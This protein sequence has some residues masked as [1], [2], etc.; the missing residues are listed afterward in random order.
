MHWHIYSVL[1][2][3]VNRKK[4]AIGARGDD[5]RSRSHLSFLQFIITGRAAIGGAI[6]AIVNFGRSR[7]SGFAINPSQVCWHQQLTAL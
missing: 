3:G 5:V 1:L 2:G 6:G 7:S 4:V